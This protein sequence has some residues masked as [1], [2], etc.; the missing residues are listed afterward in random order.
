[1]L[2]KAPIKFRVKACA[3]HFAFSLLIG[4]VVA[5]AVFRMWY[6]YPYG[7]LSEGKRLFIMVL[8][9]DVILGPLITLLIFNPKKSRRELLMDFAVVA[10]IQM[11]ALVYG[12]W[13]VYVARPVHLVFEYS[14]LV[15]VHGAD[16]DE[17][18]LK[19]APDPFKVL[20]VN[21]P[22]LLS[23]RPLNG[24]DMV[25]STLMALNGVPQAAQTNLWQPYENARIEILANAKP[26]S[27][28]RQR[29]STQTQTIDTAIREA[30]K[31]EDQLLTLPVLS[32]QQAWTALI[33]ATS[34]YPLGFL[35]IDSF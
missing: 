19:L 11:A 24:S 25:Q 35:P 10:V 15:V 16:V 1:L 26:V 9:I 20:P 7:D 17:E 18:A 33:D 3:I 6:P 5:L 4:M 30:G 27:V 21:G 2:K 29:F 28:L 34:G 31:D 22:T 32:R 12:V 8:G 14:R 13:T 23:L